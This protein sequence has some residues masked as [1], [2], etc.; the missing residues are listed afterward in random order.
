[1]LEDIKASLD[2]ITGFMQNVDNAFNNPGAALGNF[3]WNFFKECLETLDIVSADILV[4]AGLIAL[5]MYVFGWKKGK[6]IGFMCPAI[7]VIIH[8]LSKCIIK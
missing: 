7:Y 6:N 2:S 5:V 3:L 8:I 4:V 1:M